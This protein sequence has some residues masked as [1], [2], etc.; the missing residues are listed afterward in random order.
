MGKIKIDIKNIFI[1]ILWLFLIYMLLKK[2]EKEINLYEKEIEDIKKYNKL[3]IKQNDSIEL[4]NYK[5]E[6]DLKILNYG[7][8][9]INNILLVNKSE[10]KR[11][12]NKKSEISININNMG[13]NDVTRSL[14]NYIEKYR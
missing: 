10:I 2:P 8:D 11:L 7:V 5:L 4:V 1:L 14:S 3:L 13:S 12:K 6:N 9:S